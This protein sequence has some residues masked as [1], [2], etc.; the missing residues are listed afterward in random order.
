MLVMLEAVCCIQ[1]RGDG[2]GISRERT[3]SCER[4]KGFDHE[5]GG[6]LLLWGSIT[7]RFR[8]ICRQTD[9][10]GDLQML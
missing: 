10:A 6:P 2:H 7:Y 1:R 9:N 8:L 3:V 5:M 4:R